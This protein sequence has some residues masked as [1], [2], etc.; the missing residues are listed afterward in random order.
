VTPPGHQ[1]R[2]QRPARAHGQ[3]RQSQ[4]V[5]TFGPGAMVDLPDH[6]VIVA[7][8]DHW[9]GYLNH[10]IVED[11]LAATVAKLLGRP[12]E[13][14]APPAEDDDPAGSTTGITAWLFPE[15]FVAPHEAPDRAGGDWAQQRNVEAGALMRSTLFARQLRARFRRPRCARTW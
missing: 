10:P 7:G 11:R 1:G 14:Y 15:W 9:S 5:T 4:V 2:A 8:L 12:F 6:A 3:I 13:F